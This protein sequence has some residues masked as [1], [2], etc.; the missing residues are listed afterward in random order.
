MIFKRFTKSAHIVLIFITIIHARQLSAEYVFRKDGSIIKGSII[1]DDSGSISVKSDEAAIV[2][3]PRSEIMRIIYTELYLGKVYIRLTTGEMVDGYQVDED[4]DDFFFRRDITKPDEFKIP[5]KKVMFIAR[6]NPTDLAGKAST[7]NIILTWSPPFK[8]AKFYRIYMRDVKGK[9][10]TYRLYE[11]T[12]DLSCEI[13]NLKKSW[14]YEIY[15]TAV[16]DTGEESLP[17]EKVAVN[18]LPEAPE[19]LLMEEKYSEDGKTVT[20]KLRWEDVTDPK[21]RVKSYAIYKSEGGE[22]IKKGSSPGSEFIINDFPA[23][24]RHWFSVAAVN[25]LFTESEEVK[26]LY[27]AGYKV[28]IRTMAAYLYP[29]GILP[30]LAS[31]GYGVLLNTGISARKYGIGAETGYYIFNCEEGVESMSI[32][33]VMAEV[34]YTLPLFYNFSLRGIIKCGAAFSMIEY[35]VH[36]TGDPLISRITKNSGFDFMSS[37]GVSLKYD[38]SEK[39]NICGGAEYSVIFES[40][41][42]MEFAAV[43]FGAGITF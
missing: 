16:S 8:P 2:R 41:G 17:S 36:N 20:L 28:Y 7:D 25:D 32:I 24:G 4:R 14:I 26:I 19:K 22:K 1:A 30:D 15:A 10:Q 6:T 29:G 5:R 12:D 33:P 34:N 21:S 23:E 13:K 40:S 18:T 39:I 9:E 35:T 27:D 3:V 31:S 42:R 43:S 37:A 38:I 11:E